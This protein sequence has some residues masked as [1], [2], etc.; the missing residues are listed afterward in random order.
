MIPS[1]Y[2]KT[3]A[4]IAMYFFSQSRYDYD[5]CK[6]TIGD[7]AEWQYEPNIVIQGFRFGPWAGFAIDGIAGPT[8]AIMGDGFMYH[9]EFWHV[10]DS[11]SKSLQQTGYIAEDTNIDI[12][13]N[14]MTLTLGSTEESVFLAGAFYKRRTEAKTTLIHYKP[15]DS[16]APFF[17]HLPNTVHWAGPVESSYECFAD[18]PND[19]YYADVGLHYDDCYRR[20]SYAAVWDAVGYADDM[21]ILGD[22]LSDSVLK[23][24]LLGPGADSNDAGVVG[25]EHG[26][27]YP[28]CNHERWEID[29]SCYRLLA[30]QCLQDP[31]VH[32]REI[33]LNKDWS[34]NNREAEEL[35]SAGDCKDDDEL[36]RR[37]MENA[38]PKFL[39][40]IAPEFWT[41]SM[42]YRIGHPRTGAGCDKSI[43]RD[44]CKYT[45]GQCSPNHQTGQACNRMARV[46][47]HL[48]D[49]IIGAHFDAQLQGV[50][51]M[52]LAK[53]MFEKNLETGKQ[54][55]YSAILRFNTADYVARMTYVI[56]ESSNVPGMTYGQIMAVLEE[57]TNTKYDPQ[58]GASA[59][60]LGI[61]GLASL[62]LVTEVYLWTKATDDAGSNSYPRFLTSVM[63]GFV[64]DIQIGDKADEFKLP[65]ML[66]VP[67]VL[68]GILE[69]GV[70]VAESQV[71]THQCYPQW[72]YVDMVS[73]GSFERVCEVFLPRLNHLMI[74]N[75]VETAFHATIYGSYMGMFLLFYVFISGGSMWIILDASKTS[76]ELDAIYYLAP[77]I[78]FVFVVL[79]MLTMIGFSNSSLVPF[80]GR[81]LNVKVLAT[82]AFEQKGLNWAPPYMM[83]IAL[84]LQ[85]CSESKPSY[86][87]YGDWVIEFP[88][89][90]DESSE[91]RTLLHIREPKNDQMPEGEAPP[92]LTSIYDAKDLQGL[93]FDA[94]DQG[95]SNSRLALLKLPLKRLGRGGDDTDVLCCLELFA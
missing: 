92:P 66:S 83:N 48:R 53:A 46:L 6:S 86:F 91:T 15:G 26:M 58:R 34:R 33:P 42:A 54:L 49:A 2:N 20:E 74:A 79:L 71:P 80:W 27:R 31:Q 72:L 16:N 36:M 81:N 18:H 94:I 8:Q 14:S 23:A 93:P 41:C 65:P 89:Q 10:M 64:Y 87:G 75:S 7:S 5:P 21:G 13:E 17:R 28:G 38:D 95:Q 19:M 55:G 39:R 77:Q 61:T 60:W 44:A 22:L 51:K 47:L 57:E 82:T 68:R 56:P 3:E 25:D 52:L 67:E 1:T 90:P 40:Q 85:S 59:I 37:T 29:G 62:V 63:H 73:I 69:I 45:C 84:L 43:F 76:I 12:A 78:C 70:L 24:L 32:K 35:R 30:G 11:L 4:K 88:D 9:L 50:W